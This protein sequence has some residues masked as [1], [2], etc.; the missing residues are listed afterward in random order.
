MEHNRFTTW[1]IGW[2]DLNWPN[3]DNHEKIKRKAEGL[4]K[5]NATA[6]IL[7]GS[8]FRWDFLPIFPI[9]HDYIATVAEELHKYGVK[10]LDHHSV[11][12]VHRYSTREEMR[13]VIIDSG[14]HLPFSPTWEAAASWE[15][16]GKK[17]NDWRMIDVKTRKPL[18]FPQYTSEGFCHR[19]PEFK[20]AYYDYVKKLIA[21]TGIDG[22]S[23]DDGMY[24]MKH[25][26]CACKY[27]REELKRRSGID[28]PPIEDQTFWGNWDNP[29]WKDW[30]DLRL[31]ANGEFYKGIGDIIPEGFI[32][33]GCGGSSASAGAATAATDARRFLQGC[34]YANLEMSG[35]TPPYKHDPVTVNVPLGNRLS[36]ASHH[37]AAAREKNAGTF[38]TAFAFTEVSANIAW[39]VNKILGA[40]P[41]IGTLKGRLGLPDH[42]LETLPEEKD[43]VGKAYGF[44]AAHKELFEGEMVGQLAVYFSYETRDHSYFGHL[45]KGYARDYSQT[46]QALFR[47]SICPHTVFDFPENTDKYPLVLVPSP[48]KM[49]DAEITAM[50]K[51]LASGGKIIMTGP[52]ALENCVNSWNIPTH[53]DCEPMDFFATIQH[54]VWIKEPDWVTKTELDGSADE[55]EW[56]EPIEGLMYNPHRFSDS[57]VVDD[58]L[59]LCRKY[60]TPMPLKVTSSTGYLSTM[61]D[62]PDQLI[63]HF[64]AEDYDVDID[65][66]L[67]DMRFHRSRV[68]F[69]NKVEPIGISREIVIESDTK[70]E[71][72]TPFNDEPTEIELKDGICKLTLP[73]KCAY[74]LL[75]F[76]K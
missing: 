53:V 24:Y 43:I 38:G 60:M 5:A 55:Y 48:L 37:Q 49:T 67:D 29:A 40:D 33:T 23:A 35:N 36:N 1:W 10:F 20:E 21:D 11:N 16:N 75:R 45:S 52:T 41:W 34:N 13:H 72:Y 65:H 63:V 73:E 9:L 51:Y 27:C 30:I 31:D 3:L 44:E 32:L 50:N 76:R 74:A 4:A 62:S 19:N 42:I 68:N 59:A 71:V 54:G 56:S 18:Y 8:H 28:L 15:Y 64:L 14:P 22:L 47:E 69:V 26:A 46:M 66:K 7:F 39:A 2:N 25:N 58:V 57:K 61:F 17:L 70:P 12:L 6:V